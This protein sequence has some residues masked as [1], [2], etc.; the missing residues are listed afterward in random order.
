M[1]LGAKTTIIGSSQF[2]KD[3]T[4]NI[5]QITCANNTVSIHVLLKHL[6]N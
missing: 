6:E 3:F 2:D 4:Q 1:L 5:G